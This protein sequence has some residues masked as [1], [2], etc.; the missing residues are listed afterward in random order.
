MQIKGKKMK[1]R[2]R[3]NL[4]RLIREYNP[5]YDVPP[6]PRVPWYVAILVDIIQDQQ[7]EIE[8]L[9]SKLEAHG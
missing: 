8:T 1:P 4:E 2:N 5:D 6:G 3:Q 7:N 9:K